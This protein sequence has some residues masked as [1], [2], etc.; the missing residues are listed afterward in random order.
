VSFRRLRTLILREIRATFRDAFTMS[1]LIATPLGAMLIFSFVLSTDVMGLRLAVLDVD[2]SSESRQLVADVAAGGS[3]IPH[4]VDSRE[5]I[6][7]GMRAG[8]ISA[9]LIIPPGFG[10]AVQEGRAPEVQAIYDGAEAVLAGNAEGALGGLLAATGGRLRGG[11]TGSPAPRG[12]AVTT[13][14]LFNPRL[15]GTPFM[16][17]GTFGF[18]LSFLTTLITAVTIV[19]ERQAGTFDQLQVTPATSLEIL[20]GKLLPLGFVFSVDV[21]LMVV[22]AGVVLG[23]WP[24]GSI[25]FFL[26]VSAFYVMV[27]LSLGLIFSA[28][29]QTAAEAVQKTVLFSVPLV[30]LSGF[31]FP[32]RNMPT[33]LQW[34][35]ELFP[36]THYI[37]VTRAIYLRG[38]G[39]LDLGPE[40]LVLFLF[41]A[42]LV[43]M[44]LRTLEQ[45]A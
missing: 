25:P 14:V 18:V 13:Q 32:I 44:A 40:L 6:T 15:D 37:R 36:A 11:G 27:S 35:A 31:A 9:A 5:A 28:T 34:V 38:E 19:N 33:G 24:H 39:P 12:V 17:S 16:V 29:S 20:L 42:A 45:R 1:I 4:P 41:A 22:L 7:D 3:F 26:V 8:E 10:R 43:F 30:Q 2:G 21:A 23:V